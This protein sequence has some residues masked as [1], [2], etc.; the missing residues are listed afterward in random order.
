MENKILDLTK[1]DDEGFKIVKTAVEDMAN[2]GTKYIIDKDKNVTKFFNMSFDAG[3]VSAGLAMLGA[4][5]ISLG[6]DHFKFKKSK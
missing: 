2:N 1:M 3:V 4:G 6:V 5:L